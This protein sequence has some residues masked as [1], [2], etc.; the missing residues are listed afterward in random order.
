ML[1]VCS[2]MLATSPLA[3]ATVQRTFVA[4]GGND[5]NPCSITLACRTFFTALANTNANGEVIVLDGRGYGSVSIGKSVS[6]IAPPGVYAGI[7]AASGVGV[8][9]DVDK[10][11][12]VLRGCRSTVEAAVWVCS[13]PAAHASS[14]RIARSRIRRGDGI[15]VV[16]S[17]SALVN[18]AN[19]VLRNNTATGFHSCGAVEAV[20]DHV[21]ISNTRRERSSNREGT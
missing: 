7:S 17:G 13:S 15:N 12:V 9:I 5:A 3:S 6:I 10:I 18:V 8:G 16:V 21:R 19:T 2:S 11:D 4:S 20:L 14:S 1:S